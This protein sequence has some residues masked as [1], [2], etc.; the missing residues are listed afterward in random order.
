MRLGTVDVA[1]SGPLERSFRLDLSGRSSASGIRFTLRGAA[2]VELILLLDDG[3]VAPWMYFGPKIGVD[4]AVPRCRAWGSMRVDDV[5]RCR[6]AGPDRR[7]TVLSSA[8]PGVRAFVSLSSRV[9]AF[10]CSA[11]PNG[12]GVFREEGS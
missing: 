6:A 7:H 9:G 1:H 10:Y 2:D 11:S 4:L 5:D 12:L 8:P 3:T